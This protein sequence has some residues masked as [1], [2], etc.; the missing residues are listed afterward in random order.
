VIA[1]RRHQLGELEAELVRLRQ[2]YLPGR[3]LELEQQLLIGRQWERVADR[4]GYVRRRLRLD[5]RRLFRLREHKNRG[6]GNAP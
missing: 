6:A 3:P 2:E 1:A 5:E 4:A